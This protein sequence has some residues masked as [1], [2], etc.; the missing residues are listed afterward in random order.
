[1]YKFFHDFDLL[2]GLLDFEGIDVYFLKSVT[3]VFRIFNQVN[4]AEASFSNQVDHLVF[5]V[6]AL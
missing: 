2:E 3:S 4:R 1:M 5:G 6:H